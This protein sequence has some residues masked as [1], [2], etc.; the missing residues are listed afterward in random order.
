M[1]KKSVGSANKAEAHAW[2]E[3]FDGTQW[4]RV[5]PTPPEEGQDQGEGGEGEPQENPEGGGEGEPNE[6]PGE[7]EPQEQPG[8]GGKPEE[9][10]ESEVP[11]EI[12]ETLRQIKEML[13]AMKGDEKP[14][15]AGELGR[16]PRPPRRIRKNW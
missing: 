10:K 8:E 12:Q 9:Q 13:E 16:M 4:I 3:I 7:G 11:F 5:D 2:A 6:N 14:L 15:G 1:I